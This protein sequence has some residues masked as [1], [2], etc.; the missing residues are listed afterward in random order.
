MN[1][2][3]VTANIEKVESVQTTSFPTAPKKSPPGRRY[4]GFG[5]SKCLKSRLTNL[6]RRVRNVLLISYLYFFVLESG[7]LIPWKKK[8]QSICGMLLNAQIRLGK[9][10]FLP[11]YVRL[12]MNTFYL[13][14]YPRFPLFFNIKFHASP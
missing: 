2:L 7:Y 4:V 5:R 11:C 6:K 9:L 3:T 12:C 13:L 14:I 1:I 10:A 8:N